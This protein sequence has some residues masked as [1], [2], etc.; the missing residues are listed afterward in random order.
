M[1]TNS[2]DSWPQNAP[3]PAQDVLDRLMGQI[4]LRVEE[5]PDNSYTTK[6]VRGGVAL[7]G[8]KVTEEAAEVV[9]AAN[10]SK[11]DDNQHLIYESCDLLYHL[12]VLL[13]SRGVSLDDLRNELARREGTSGIVEK[14]NRGQRAPTDEN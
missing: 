6:L 10:N 14:L 3:N 5:L 11:A 9:D 4:R 2:P 12:F 7:M 13:G 8:A 1:T